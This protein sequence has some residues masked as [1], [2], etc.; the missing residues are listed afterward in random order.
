MTDYPEIDV[1]RKTGQEKFHIN[2]MPLSYGLLDFWQWSASDLVNNA[3]RGVLA[4]FIVA[5]AVGQVKG[6]RTEWDAVD[7]KTQDGIKIEVKSSAYIQSWLQQKLSTIQFDIK[8]TQGWDAETNEFSSEVKR[9]ADVYVFCILH[10]EDQNT[11][12]P[13]NLDQWS[14]YVLPTEALNEAVGEQKTISL[15]S[16]QKLNPTIATYAALNTSIQDAAFR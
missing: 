9:Q 12:N 8:C 5:S 2:G 16:L 14:F 1:I 7:L 13:L 11:I 10:H 15:S 3:M 6:H 4:E